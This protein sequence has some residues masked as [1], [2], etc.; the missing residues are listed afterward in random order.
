[1]AES[2]E[3]SN[4][5]VSIV[6]HGGCFQNNYADISNILLTY[7]KVF[8]ESEI[9][10]SISSSDFIDFDKSTESNVCSYKKEMS[11]FC[12]LVNHCADKIAYARMGH[13][14]PPVFVNGNLCNV[15]NLIEAAYNGLLL[16]T[17][18]FVLRVRNDLLFKDRTFIETYKKLYR[19][20]FRTGDRTVFNLPVMISSLYTL[21][22]F[23]GVRLPFHY[24]DWF[25]FG[26][27]SDIRPMWDL[28]LVTLDFMTY[29]RSHYA[30]PGSREKERNFFS[31]LAVEQYI[32]FEFFR[33][34]FKDIVLEY[35]N[36][37]HS[38]E[39]SIDI[40][41]DN[42][43]VCDIYDTNVYFPKYRD[44]FEPYSDRNMRITQEA[45]TYL[46]SHSEVSPSELLSIPRGRTE[47]YAPRIF[48]MRIGAEYLYTD[49]GVRFGRSIVIP[50]DAH[51]GCACFGPY[52]TLAKGKYRVLVKISAAYPCN[53]S[54]DFKISAKFDKAE[55]I[56]ACKNY[57]FSGAD[58]V[59]QNEGYC[60]NIEFYINE[61]YVD[62]FEIVINTFSFIDMSIDFIEIYRL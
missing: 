32:H 2:L 3:I 27:L 34:K 5:D 12:H 38:I 39:A 7:R 23:S 56:L 11:N 16:A 54:G 19:D 53:D 58:E 44:G 57:N 25:H 21:N 43:I 59:S 15:N 33:K 9:I 41:L 60:F 28:P 55:N 42:F 4:K 46:S 20:Y 47:M 17:R 37:E 22:P 36:D 52:I 1:M 50:H 62:N 29:Y 31:K 8:R 6:I 51:P 13:P 10:F 26:L 49:I 18:K 30:I 45:W 14:L 48:P 35:H 61:K 40:L 24:G